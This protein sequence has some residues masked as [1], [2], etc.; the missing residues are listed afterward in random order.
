M[1]V[2]LKLYQE[3]NRGV[4]CF[5][6]RFAFSLNYQMALLNQKLLKNPLIA[7]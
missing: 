6:T 1:C 3:I 4:H 2:N 7:I 5:F